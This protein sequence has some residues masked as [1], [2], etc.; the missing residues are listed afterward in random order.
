MWLTEFCTLDVMSLTKDLPPTTTDSLV[1][2]LANPA[3]APGSA[4]AAA[5]AAAIAAAR[6]ERARGGAADAA[7][8]AAAEDA[9]VLWHACH[10]PLDPDRL[11]LGFACGG[12][13]GGG[14][15]SF[16]AASGPAGGL[17]SASQVAEAE[18]A[19][20]AAWL[21]EW[22]AGLRA[23]LQWATWATRQR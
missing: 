9:M 8:A 23:K 2:P 17:T 13:G 18:E 15:G 10:A 3:F 1:A 4:A 11:G 5:A 21:R 16:R 20:G 7:G 12:G 19:M 14:G 22:M 6:A